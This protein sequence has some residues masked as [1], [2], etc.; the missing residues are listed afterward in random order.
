MSVTL[1]AAVEHYTGEHCE[2]ACIGVAEDAIMPM[3]MP[4]KLQHYEE[5]VAAGGC[6]KKG[7]PNR[8]S[9]AP[10]DANGLS[11]GEFACSN[12]D[13]LSFL[14]VGEMGFNT[15]ANDIWG[16]VDSVTGKEWA[17]VCNQAGTTF[18]DVT[19]PYNPDVVAK[20]DTRTGTRPRLWRDPKVYNDH[21]YVVMDSDNGGMQVFDMTRLRA[22]QASQNSTSQF[23]TVQEDSIYTEFRNAHNLVVNEDTGYMYAVGSN[24]CR[25][26]LHSIDLSDPKNPTF[27]GCYD[28]DGYTHD[29][30]CVVYHGPD[31]RYT[32][33]EVCFNYNEDTLTVA[34][35]TDH[36]NPTTISRNPYIGAQ[37]SHQ[38]W[39]DDEQRF[40]LL[41]DELDENCSIDPDGSLGI[42]PRPDLCFSDIPTYIQGK[43]LTHIWNVEDLENPV[44]IGEFVSSEV[45]TDHNLYIADGYA[46]LSNYCAGLRI[47]D[48]AD[49]REGKV[50]EVAFFDV[51]PDCA[52]PAF[53]GMWSNY[54]F[55]SGNLVVTSMERG[56][57]VLRWNGGKNGEKA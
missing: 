27:A 5:C 52:D 33:K 54:L 11:N 28:E 2:G 20:M 26:G 40:L 1:A 8:V 37:Y 12:V 55:P 9:D 41:N 14:S 53:T 17:V 13:M 32:G 7:L 30:Q 15:D 10:C 3:V 16:W 39:V 35:L 46:Y 44:K 43:T 47:L 21:A 19:D 51:E 6:P 57:F 34:D 25:G 42:N 23:F 45:A 50:E 49:V 38:G 22:M 4:F 18:V 31:T 56:L 29:A 24:T 48:M 36:A